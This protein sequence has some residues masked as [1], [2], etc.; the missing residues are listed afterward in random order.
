M[1]GAGGLGFCS[2]FG[3]AEL[4]RL[5]RIYTRGGDA[6]KT[7]LGDG[8]RVAKSG[9]RVAAFGAVDELNA[10]LGVIRADLEPKATALDDLLARVQNELFDLGADLACPPTAQSA[11]AD[12]NGTDATNTDANG[13]DTTT[14]T[15]TTNKDTTKAAR[16]DTALRII[17]AQVEALEQA[18]DTH[19]AGLA[20]LTSFILPGGTRTAAGLHLARTMA[21]RSERALFALAES[22]SVGESVLRYM[23]R[24]SDLL[25]VLS[26]VA[27]DGGAADV[28]WQP[29]ATRSATRDVPPDG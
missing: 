5:T 10:V 7:S 25:F 3:E 14:S 11:S 4:V 27:N 19:N 2:G 22:E 13:T 20:P 6:G 1:D 12:T 15:D 29:G 24:L 28:L 17:P 26:R 16:Q 21:R 9:L 18:I 23:N 8:S